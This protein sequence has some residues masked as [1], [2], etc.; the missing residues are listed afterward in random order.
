MIKQVAMAIAVIATVI[1]PISQVQ[2]QEPVWDAIRFSP[3]LI[4]QDIQVYVLSFLHLYSHPISP[5]R[6]NISVKL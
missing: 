6:R 2:A 5:Q 4:E 1:A 3:A